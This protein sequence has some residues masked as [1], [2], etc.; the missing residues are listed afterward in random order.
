M[1]QQQTVTSHVHGWLMNVPNYRQDYSTVNNN[2]IEIKKERPMSVTSISSEDSV[3]LD[4]LIN[5]NYTT[6]MEE[7][8]A[9]LSALSLLDLDDSKEDFWKVDIAYIPSSTLFNKKPNYYNQ[10]SNESNNNSFQKGFI[11]TLNISSSIQYDTPD[12][13]PSFVHL[14]LPSLPVS[15][16]SPVQR[17]SSFSSET[18]INS[19]STITYQ[20][21]PS[22]RPTESTS[23]SSYGSQS[24]TTSAFSRSTIPIAE[25]TIR[26]RQQRKLSSSVSESTSMS[27]SNLARRATHIPAPSTNHKPGI[28]RQSIIPQHTKSTSTATHSQQQG[29]LNRSPSRLTSKRASHIPAPSLAQRSA[30]SLGMA[31]KTSLSQHQPSL[32]SRSKPTNGTIQRNLGSTKSTNIRTLRK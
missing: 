25:S 8:E 1:K 15:P 4:E 12:H 11:N 22:I 5:V 32:L 3:D 23:T 30:T 9:D 13:S 18:S 21:R 24:T 27:H 16:K 29:I 19:Q 20:R 10:N 2:H 28:I 14:H 31:P 7:E 6:I 26:R 17:S